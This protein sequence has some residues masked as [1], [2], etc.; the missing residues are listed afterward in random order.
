MTGFMND[1]PEMTD[2]DFSRR[3]QREPQGSHADCLTAGPQPMPDCPRDCFEG[4]MLNPV[5]E[6]RMQDIAMLREVAKLFAPGAMARFLASL[7]AAIEE[8]LRALQGQVEVA[9]LV[10]VRQ[11]HRLAGTAGTLGC[12][13]LS[14]AARELEITD[15][16]SHELRQKFIAVAHATL[17]AIDGYAAA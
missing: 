2:A 4:Q 10:L 1:Q 16:G 6:E 14:A 11:L 8:A 3:A 9:P 12:V 17:A 15:V 13:A 7:A 5:L